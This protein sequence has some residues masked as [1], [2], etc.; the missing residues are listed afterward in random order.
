MSSWRLSDGFHED[1]IRTLEEYE[2]LARDI[3]RTLPP[4]EWPQWVKNYVHREVFGPMKPVDMTPYPHRDALDEAG[5]LTLPES[6][7]SEKPNGADLAFRP[8]D[9]VRLPDGSFGTVMQNYENEQNEDGTITQWMQIK[10]DDGKIVQ[11]PDGALRFEQGL[12]ST[13]MPDTLPWGEAEQNYYRTAAGVGIP[14]NYTDEDPLDLQG[15]QPVFQSMDTQW[16]TLPPEQ[17]KQAV[18]NAFRATMLSPRMNLK[19][20]AVLYQSLMHVDPNESNPDVFENTIR[21]LKSRWDAQGQTSI[22]QDPSSVL[23]LDDIL[24]GKFQPGIWTNIRRLALLGPFAD[25]LYKAAL[26]DVF[27]YGGTGHYFRNA[28]LS[29]NIPGVKAKVASFAWLALA[30]MS[31]ELGTIDVHMMRHLQQPEDA[32][33]NT[34]H[35]LQLEDQLR[36]ERDQQYPDTPLT[37]YQWGVW[38]KRRTPGYHQDHSPLRP[39]DPTPYTDVQW[40]NPTRAPRPQQPQMTDP[41]QLGFQFA[42]KVG[43]QLVKNPFKPAPQAEIQWVKPYGAGDFEGFV[44]DVMRA[45]GV[46]PYGTVYKDENSWQPKDPNDPSG[47]KVL[48]PEAQQYA[49]DMIN[50]YHDQVLRITNGAIP[51]GHWSDDNYKRGLR[52]VVSQMPVVLQN[53]IPNEDARPTMDQEHADQY[54]NGILPNDTKMRAQYPRQTPQIQSKW[55]II[56]L[57]GYSIQGQVV[58][59]A[60]QGTTNGIAV[61]PDQQSPDE[62]KQL[63]DSLPG[64]SEDYQKQRQIIPEWALNRGGKTADII[65]NPDATGYSYAPGVILVSEWVDVN[66][67]WILYH[68]RCVGIVAGKGGATS[69]GVV[70]ARERNIPIIVNVPQWNQIQAGDHIELDSRTGVIHGNGGTT[71]QFDNAQ[72]A[73]E[74]V[75]AFVWS[76]GNG[77]YQPIPPGSGGAAVLH[78]PMMRQLKQEGKF[79]IQDYAIGVIYDDGR[80]QMQGTPTDEEALNQWLTSLHPTKNIAPEP[81][82]M[83][84]T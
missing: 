70:V 7:G 76:Q 67:N 50:K 69:H 41:N 37:Q 83:A 15:K 9:R 81:T 27:Q 32:P 45:I 40:P 46:D 62:I 42:K 75:I 19:G 29:M 12:D 51:A 31:S 72:E 65:Q 33:R 54:Y 23:P 17:G 49:T 36:Q 34:Q 66:D 28:V 61:R 79:N 71:Q 4:E 68:D 74:P 73:L 58:G 59:A 53:Q 35:Y 25:E 63:L 38:D 20:N 6:W 14:A 43:W 16:W 3:I 80:V 24:S 77:L 30:P 2:A 78:R 52:E 64:H 26:T 55:S 82:A 44:K 13:M 10:R 18:I 84:L 11:A 47:G 22:G 5:D 48:T 57:S 21:D 56:R 1:A 39:V 60:P 8:G